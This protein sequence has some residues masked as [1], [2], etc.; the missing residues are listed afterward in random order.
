MEL[1]Y[2][3][4]SENVQE[5]EG[6]VELAEQTVSITLGRESD[7]EEDEFINRE[8]QNGNLRALEYSIPKKS[9]TGL[10]FHDVSYEVV[11]RKRCKKLPNKTI[12][13]SLRCVCL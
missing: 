9:F 4:Y 3:K 12:L 8:N 13:H 7:D 11:Q 6:E 5:G 2:T 10:S 1:S